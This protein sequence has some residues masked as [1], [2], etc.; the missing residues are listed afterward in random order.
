MQIELSPDIFTHENFQGLNFLVH[1][2]FYKGRYDLFIDLAAL[3]GNDAYERLD[4]IDRENIELEFNKTITNGSKKT[5]KT[6]VVSESNFGNKY[7]TIDDA[8]RYLTQ[9]VSILVENSLNDR[10]FIEKLFSI[11]DNSGLLNIHVRNGW[12]QFENAGGCSNVTNFLESRLQ[13]YNAQK[14][15]NY[16]FLRCFVI[17]DSDSH[18]NGAP[19]KPEYITL[20]EY[21]HE[22]KVP[23][24]IFEKRAMENYLPDEVMR[25]LGTGDLKPWIDAYLNL[26]D[27]QKDFLNID[28]GFKVIAKNN[29]VP[30]VQNLFADLSDA[31][32]NI[33]N[34]GFR[35]PNLKADLPKKFDHFHCHKETLNDRIKHQQN[36]KEFDTI[37]NTLLEL[38]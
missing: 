7:F 38:I 4:R 21:L 33:L 11:Y 31:N 36:P 12:L 8:I 13:S 35:F 17:L 23:I 18:F 2:C 14:K 3:K 5:K 6:V 34:T 16:Y 22:K 10:Y 30:Q 29:L 1:V 25:S 32:F 20:Q 15:D 28:K 9:P 37:V 26:S 24:H 19:L 27:V